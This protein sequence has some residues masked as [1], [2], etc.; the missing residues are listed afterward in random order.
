M[1]VRYL[2][3][4]GAELLAPSRQWERYLVRLKPRDGRVVTWQGTD[5]HRRYFETGQRPDLEKL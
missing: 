3:S 1:A 2:G 5:W 4:N